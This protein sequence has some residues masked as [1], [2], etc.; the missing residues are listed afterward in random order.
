MV[1]V[2]KSLYS[3]MN[4]NLNGMNKFILSKMFEISSTIVLFRNIKNFYMSNL[5]LYAH[6]YHT[7]VENEKNHDFEA[8]DPARRLLAGF[9]LDACH[10][11]RPG[12]HAR[13]GPR[14][15]MGR[16]G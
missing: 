12:R 1:H 13:S 11:V 8:A 4:H 6:S 14:P 5:N 9:V 3:R 15:V 2:T 7:D 16:G 10:A